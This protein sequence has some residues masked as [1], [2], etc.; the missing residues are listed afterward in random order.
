V[1]IDSKLRACDLVKLRIDDICSGANVRRRATIV[2][3]KT[4][5][6]VPFEITEQSTGNT[7]KQGA[8]LGLSIVQEIMAAHGGDLVITSAQ[9]GGTTAS[10]RFPEALVRTD[11]LNSLTVNSLIVLKLFDAD[12]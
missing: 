7:R 5:R 10:L 4:G 8:G 3:K 11:E 2:Q 1:A 9:D 6:P 12:K